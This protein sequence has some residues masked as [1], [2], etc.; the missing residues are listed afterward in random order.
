MVHF[1]SKVGT[2]QL[3]ADHTSVTSHKQLVV[4]WYTTSKIIVKFLFECIQ[5]HH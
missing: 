5:S 3:L 2:V 4:N 1:I